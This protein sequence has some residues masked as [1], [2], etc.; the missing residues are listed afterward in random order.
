MTGARPSA[1]RAAIMVCVACGNIVLRR[2]S[3]PANSFA[4]A[5]LLV[6]AA[7]PSDPFTA[8]CQLSFLSVFVLIWGAARWLAPRELTPVEQLIEESR[9]LAEKMLR[10]LIRT[11][12]HGFL[13]GTIITLVNAPLV[14]AWQNVVSPVAV[15]LGLPLVALTSIALISGFILLVVSP[16]GII[17]WPF[18][19]VTEWC[20]SGC[21]RLVHLGDRV[22]I[23]HIYTP[24][25]PM[26]WLVG[27]YLLVVGLVLLDGSWSRR[28]LIW[29]LVWTLLGVVVGLQPRTTDEVRI[30]FLAVGHGGCVAIE[31][32]DGRV[33]LYDAGTTAG[34][35]A[36][37]RVIAP[38]LWSRGIDRIDEVF[39]SHADLDHFNGVPELLRRFTVGRVTMTP[40]FADKESPGV[41]AVLGALQ[42]RGIETRVVS[43]GEKFTAGAVTFD[44]LHPPR[45]GPPGNENSRSLVLL[46]R[47][48]GHSIL[49]TGDLEGEGQNLTTG[50]PIAPVD[51]M[52]APHHGGKSANA[53][54]GTRDKPEAGVMATWARP[55]L[56][57]SS[58]RQGLRTTDYH[59]G[60]LSRVGF[61][62]SPSRGYE[63]SPLYSTVE[64]NHGNDLERSRT[65]RRVVHTAS[66]PKAERS[67]PRTP[68]LA[69]S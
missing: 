16:L 42:S 30:A 25:P 69:P 68:P 7:N 50:K 65:P 32:P 15:L 43:A 37:R 40:S 21:E 52:L 39:L 47:H 29:L 9:S 17:G 64:E 10:A 61:D 67:P 4:F 31:T 2:P 19:R 24:A 38:Y 55:K 3:Y 28:C 33:L 46:M 60:V 35:D 62:N 63:A 12:W 48:E 34:P 1:I 36:V 26:W 44:V 6:I 56:L 13:I 57:V 23:G 53:P 20:L 8:G 54:R 51:V 41:A 27:F 22:A 59:F 11:I 18:S 58:Q 66:L 5:W 45:V 49:L 14:L